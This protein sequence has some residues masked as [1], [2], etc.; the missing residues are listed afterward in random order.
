EEGVALRRWK[1]VDATL[2]ADPDDG[3][4]ELV[5]APVVGL[6]FQLVG[7]EGEHLPKEIPGVSMLQRRSQARCL[8]APIAEDQHLS[9]LVGEML[10][11]L[12]RGLLSELRFDKG[13]E[14]LLTL[15]T[16]VRDTAAPPG[17]AGLAH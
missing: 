13:G 12:L 6:V 5:H 15:G 14:R 10:P 7:S 17:R 16:E 4:V 1:Q 8:L 11:Y 9:P 3:G 2:V